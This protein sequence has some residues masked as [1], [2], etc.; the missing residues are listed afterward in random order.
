MVKNTKKS[1]KLDT[2]QKKSNAS[3][4]TGLDVAIN[5]SPGGAVTSQQK[6]KEKAKEKRR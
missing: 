4:T 5:A 6:P 1:T 3:N 2:Q